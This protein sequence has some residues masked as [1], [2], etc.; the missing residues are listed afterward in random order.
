MN[1][2]RMVTLGAAHIVQNIHQERLIFMLKKCFLLYFF[3]NKCEKK[4]LLLGC[5]LTTCRLVRRYRGIS[6]IFFKN[7]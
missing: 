4:L 1:K 6:P 7:M 2:P 5:E 3:D